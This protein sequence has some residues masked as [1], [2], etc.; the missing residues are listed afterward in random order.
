MSLNLHSLH[1]Q[2]TRTAPLRVALTLQMSFCSI[3]Q[4]TLSSHVPRQQSPRLLAF[5]W[6]RSS[7]HLGRPAGIA[8]LP[9]SNLLEAAGLSAVIISLCTHMF[10]E[11]I[12]SG[13]TCYIAAPQQGLPDSE[14]EPESMR[15]Q[16]LHQPYHHLPLAVIGFPWFSL[17]LLQPQREVTTDTY[18]TVM[19]TKM[20]GEVSR[21]KGCWA[22]IPLECKSQ[23]LQ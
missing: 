13:L 11:A 23:P 3:L 6:L 14:P 2:L 8:S 18:L 22:P 15:V 21:R 4:S 9:C 16:Y 7:L 19:C 17:T 10:Q 5:C 20:G 12:S 1:L